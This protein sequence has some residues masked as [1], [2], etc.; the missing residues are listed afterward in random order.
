MKK[1]ILEEVNRNR[2]IMGLNPIME[3]WEDNLLKILGLD[4]EKILAKTEAELLPV[5]KNLLSSIEK[6]AGSDA[7]KV[8]RS[9]E[10]GT[11][12]KEFPEFFT[13]L[14]NDLFVSGDKQIKT[15]FKDSFMRAYPDLEKLESNLISDEMK[16]L[17]KSYETAGQPQKIKN[18]EKQFRDEIKMLPDGEIKNYF[19]KLIDDAFK[20]AEKSA[21]LSAKDFISNYKQVA[22]KFKTYA[23][24]LEKELG[25][26]GIK[27][28]KHGK[29]ITENEAVAAWD[30]MKKSIK[31]AAED[32]EKL[33][34]NDPATQK[35][36]NE[37]IT[38]MKGMDPNYVSRYLYGYLGKAYGSFVAWIKDF[39][40]LKAPLWTALIHFVLMGSLCYGV[41]KA[42]QYFK[43]TDNNVGCVAYA[44]AIGSRAW[45]GLFGSDNS[46]KPADTDKAAEIP[47]MS[48]QEI[49]NEFRAWLI[50]KDE[51]YSNKIQNIS[52]DSKDKT[53]VTLEFKKGDGT[54][55]KV[56]FKRNGVNDYSK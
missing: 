30:D 52:I 35:L 12:K 19:T 17:V 53:K 34:Y 10:K 8:L 24:N 29:S 6:Y 45:E 54:I 14:E 5:E 21:D 7:D 47:S 4:A 33:N 11:F 9:M 28:V 42:I 22:N 44:K 1:I 39:A 38:K 43:K 20:G 36:L 16:S 26:G 27:I 51:K 13:K 15:A 55:I 3:Q 32:F 31:K 46:E 37:A 56:P 41:S 23:D 50:S 25:G 2:Q 49:S 48:D 18:Y 40:G